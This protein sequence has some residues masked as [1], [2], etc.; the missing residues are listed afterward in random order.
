MKEFAAAYNNI[1][2]F[3]NSQFKYS[4]E[5][6]T[7]GVLAGDSTLRRIQSNLQTQIIR[8]VSNQFTGSMVADRPVWNSTAMEA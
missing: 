5:T 7:A 1:A 3:I 8:S 6:G 4:P 2:E